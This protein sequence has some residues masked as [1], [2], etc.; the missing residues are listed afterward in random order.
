MTAVDNRTVPPLGQAH[1][2]QSQSREGTEP[3]AALDEMCA[4]NN[5][6]PKIFTSALM[7]RCR[8]L[9]RRAD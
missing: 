6:L 2:S 9:A 7:A 1:D 5:Q 3:T 8:A 4:E